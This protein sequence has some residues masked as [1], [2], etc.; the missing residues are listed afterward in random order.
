[1]PAELRRDRS[2]WGLLALSLL[3]PIFTA[4]I[5]IPGTRAM[6][7]GNTELSDLVGRLTAV[8][9]VTGSCLFMGL[10]TLLKRG[11]DTGSRMFFFLS[12]S[13]GLTAGS[14]IILTG[15]DN[16]APELRLLFSIGCFMTSA[17]YLQYRLTFPRFLGKRPRWW[18]SLLYLP[19]LPGIAIVFMAQGTIM[20][21]LFMG[22]AVLVALAGVVT[23]WVVYFH[24]D[25]S[26]YRQRLRTGSAGLVLV[27]F[28]FF[29]GYLVPLLT[30]WYGE[31]FPAWATSALAIL[32]LLG[33]F[34]P[35]NFSSLYIL[36]RAFQTLCGFLITTLV[37]MAVIAGYSAWIF[38]MISPSGHTRIVLTGALALLI[39]VGLRPLLNLFRGVLRRLVFRNQEQDPQLAAKA[40]QALASALSRRELNQVLTRDIPGWM[41]LSGGQLWFGESANAPT[42][43]GEAGSLA[44]ELTFQA[45]VRA[46][47]SLL[48]PQDG[49]PF[50]P[51]EREVLATVAKQAEVALR[52]VLLVETLRRQ[53]DEIRAAQ[54]LL[55]Q[56]QHQ[57]IRSRENERSRL[58]R[59]LHD[60]PVQSLV[61][62]NL[63]VGL[64]EPL[65]SNSVEKI[66]ST[67]IEIRTEMKALIAEL[68]EVCATLRPPLLDTL[69]LGSAL[70]ALAV[71]WG[72]ENGIAVMTE[73]DASEDVLCKLSDEA[74]V[75][76][77]RIVQEALH[78]IGKHAR[79]TQVTVRLQCN[80]S[81]LQLELIDNGAGFAVPDTFRDLTQNGHFGLVGMR[82]RVNLIGGKWDLTSTPGQ[83]TCITVNLPVNEHV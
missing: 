28:F 22:Y 29:A 76:L 1:M 33:W 64:L 45:K 69:G 6:V 3:L 52:N 67:L 66:G 65:D 83:G 81:S 26:V 40:S 51:E 80:E 53:L 8:I 19:V 7:L 11:S 72:E 59:D 78:N 42:R 63:A 39:G 27:V 74:T 34:I 16:I 70:E 46:I 13:I 56:A 37:I 15:T 24:W 77:Y 49:H 62:L 71:E 18:L 48:P 31:L 38:P 55:A 68:R 2:P 5:L 30:E 61:A 58:A 23:G 17:L 36:D 35:Q 57:L 60:G 41:R 44:F 43:K 79:A 75:N 10:F 21:R 54:D 73:I 9:L 4:L 20:A 47:W 82:E 32:A 12:L 50:L 25:R 14:G